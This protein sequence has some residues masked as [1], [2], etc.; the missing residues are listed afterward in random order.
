MNKQKKTY[1]IILNTSNYELGLYKTVRNISLLEGSPHLEEIIILSDKEIEQDTIL[2]MPTLKGI[3]LHFSDVQNFSV[4]N[5]K[6]EILLFQNSGDYISLNLLER[7][8][9]IQREENRI[10]VPEEKVFYGNKSYTHTSLSSQNELFTNFSILTNNIWG[11]SFLILKKDYIKIQRSG[12]YFT[13]LKS[14]YCDV[15]SADMIVDV[16][17]QTLSFIYVGQNFDKKYPVASKK[18][19]NKRS[20]EII[21]SEI[22]E[23]EDQSISLFPFLSNQS[24]KMQA[25]LRKIKDK[26]D[27]RM[28]LKK[29]AS[30]LFPNLYLRLF[31]LKEKTKK[32]EDIYSEWML[33]EWKKINIIEPKLYP[34]SPLYKESDTPLNKNIDNYL[35]DMLSH[36]PK[37]LDVLILC[38]WLKRGGADKLVINLIKGL[39]QEFPNRKVGLIMTE[40][41]SS[42]IL[43]EVNKDIYFFDFGNSF[44]DLNG[45]ERQILLKRFLIEVNADK[46]VNVNSHSLFNL[47]LSDSKELSKY[48]DYYC[49]CFS[50]SRTKEG[51]LTGFA[52]D[53]IPYIVNDLKLVITDNHNIIKVLSEMFGLDSNSFSV[54]YQP[55]H[56]IAIESKDYTSKDSWDI[57]WASRIDYEKLPG[58]LQKLLAKAEGLNMNFHIYGSSVMDKEFNLRKLK[59]YK[60]TYTYGGYKGGL[61]GIHGEKYDLFLYTSW[62]DGMPNALLEAIS[63]GLPVVASNV[64]GISEI[65]KNGK[66]GLLVDD[67]F[68]EDEYLEKLIQYTRMANNDLNKIRRNAMQRL[69]EEHSWEKYRETLQNIFK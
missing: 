23:E 11:S 19:F 34:L 28:I 43:S 31:I 8:G 48:S 36:F 24:K 32:I 27:N 55:I 62:F 3:G 20:A 60:N 39:K 35:Y 14:F 25:I 54:L 63:L 7:F 44:P 26:G 57:L 13:D 61:H 2:K 56:S 45:P 50:P 52:F 51:Q 40:K 12:K 33:S 47:L 64:G 58:V 6:G 53:Y 37:E 41:T 29:I 59:K 65:I 17:P 42:E 21:I 1:S 67:I 15:L 9:E 49:F 18:I 22:E 30:E 46:V 66:T 16:I 4:D 10:Y 5:C 68:N 69:H 38:P